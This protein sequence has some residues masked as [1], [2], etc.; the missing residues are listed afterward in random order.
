M[1]R[2]MFEGR[3]WR[4]RQM[5]RQEPKI[6]VRNGFKSSILKWAEGRMTDECTVAR[7][8][9]RWPAGFRRRSAGGSSIRAASGR[10]PG[11]AIV[12]VG[13]NPASEVYVRNKLKAGRDAAF[14]PISNGC[15]RPPRSTMC[16]RSSSG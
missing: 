12:L 7:R 6:Q 11:L 9:W 8:R 10:P 2:L 15:P 4:N 5:L 1:N 13:H 14:A 3:K 16:S